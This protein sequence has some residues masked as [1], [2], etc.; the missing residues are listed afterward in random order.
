MR[1][2]IMYKLLSLVYYIDE[3]GISLWSFLFLDYKTQGLKVSNFR[4]NLCFIVN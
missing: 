4:G 3:K 1:H 2:L